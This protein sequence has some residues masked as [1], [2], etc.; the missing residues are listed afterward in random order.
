VK[1]ASQVTGANGRKNVAYEAHMSPFE[2]FTSI[3]N[4]KENSWVKV[5]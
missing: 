1:L 3:A 5:V 4:F 2:S